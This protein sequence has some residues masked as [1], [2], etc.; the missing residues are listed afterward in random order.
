MSFPK[1]D[2]T[3]RRRESTPAR[4]LLG[5]WGDVDI[6]RNVIN[7]LPAH[8]ICQN[9]AGLPLRDGD[10]KDEQRQYAAFA[11]VCRYVFLTSEPSN[12]WR[13]RESSIK[14][15]YDF[16]EMFKSHLGERPRGAWS[17]L[18]KRVTNKIRVV[19]A[20]RAYLADSLPFLNKLY[21]A[22]PDLDPTNLAAALFTEV[23]PT[24]AHWAQAIAHTVNY[25][26]DDSRAQARQEIVKLAGLQTQQNNEQI[27]AYIHAALAEDPP[28]W[29]VYRTAHMDSVVDSVRIPAS[30]RVFASIKEANMNAGAE[31]RSPILGIE[32]HGLLA[33]KF[34]EATAPQ[35]IGGILALKHLKR[36]PGLAGRFNRFVETA[37]EAPQQWYVN[38]HSDLVPWPQSL[39]VEYE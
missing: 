8:W 21:K 35:V 4:D 31:A 18:A 33:P 22:Q 3:N 19:D 17:L 1:G 25:Y 15:Y 14:T 39:V 34:F 32:E 13:L 9:L 16:V 26:L 28:V 38:A 37:H 12:D 5:S 6:V 10:I 2:I 29:G 30:T 24:A 23:V 7:V 20:N 27:A 36:A 11:D